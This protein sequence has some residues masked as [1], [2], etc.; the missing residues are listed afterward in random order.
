MKKLIVV[1][2]VVLSVAASVGAAEVGSTSSEVGG[3]LKYWVPYSHLFDVYSMGYG[4]EVQYRYW[5]FEPFGVAVSVGAA[6]WKVDS[7]TEAFNPVRVD[8]GWMTMVPVGA[9]GLFRLWDGGT[10]SLTFDAGVRYVKQMS[11]LKLA[12]GRDVSVDDGIVSVVGLRGEV[13]VTEALSVFADVEHQDDIKKG[14]IDGGKMRNNELPAFA[15]DL[16]VTFKF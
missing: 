7:S 1:V 8:G 12:N 6:N 15:F 10:W 5:F 3:S 4:A 9:S 16:G 11:D 2:L 13:N 14:E